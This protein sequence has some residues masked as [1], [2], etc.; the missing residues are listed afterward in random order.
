MTDPRAAALA[1]ALHATFMGGPGGCL[2]AADAQHQAFH[3]SDAAAIL[4]ALPEGWCGHAS[5]EPA[6]PTAMPCTC[7]FIAERDF[8]HQ[9][10]CQWL[11]SPEP[12]PLDVDRPGILDDSIEGNLQRVDAIRVLELALASQGVPEVN[13]PSLLRDIEEGG[14]TLRLTT[15]DERRRRNDRGQSS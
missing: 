13:A 8:A 12:A 9:P 15:N 11:A 1:E 2:F 7:G 5:P 4:A 3:E 14:Y 6:P 10:D